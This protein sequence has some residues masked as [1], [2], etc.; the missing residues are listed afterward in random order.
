MASY[1]T[2]Q[3]NFQRIED[4]SKYLNAY[5]IDY[6]V[7]EFSLLLFDIYNPIGYIEGRDVLIDML[8]KAN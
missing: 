7:G 5:G 3:F 2:V 4:Y 6:I 8:R 1:I